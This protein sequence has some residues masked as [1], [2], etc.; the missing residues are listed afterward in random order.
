MT[1]TTNPIVWTPSEHDLT[2]SS[3]AQFR[4]VVNQKYGLSLQTYHDLHGWS[5]DPV[6]AEDFWMELFEFL[7]MRASRLP[8]RAFEKVSRLQNIPAPCHMNKK[9][10]YHSIVH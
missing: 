1:K 8:M 9:N 7:D 2:K 6:T 4:N 3:L 10:H 5:I